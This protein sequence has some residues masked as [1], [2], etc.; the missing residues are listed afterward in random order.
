MNSFITL[1]YIKEIK[2][3]FPNNFNDL[4]EDISNQFKIDQNELITLQFIFNITNGEKMIIEINDE[5]KYQYFKNLYENN[6]E[7]IEVNIR[8]YN[9]KTN[10]EYRNEI[11]EEINQIRSTLYKQEKNINDLKNNVEN[12]QNL[13]KIVNLNKKMEAYNTLLV[14]QEKEK[15]K[16][17]NLFFSSINETIDNNILSCEYIENE[18]LIRTKSTILKNYVIEHNILIKNTSKN[19]NEWP[20]DTFLRCVNDDSDIYFYHINDRIKKTQKEGVEN[21]YIFQ[22]LVLFKNYKNIKE[23]EYDL[24]YQLINDFYGVIGD[25]Y[26]NLI[27]KVIE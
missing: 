5:E 11:N 12:N 6:C 27:I 13:D 17:S 8:N 14:S 15:N 18:K 24:K 25:D 20:I 9:F 10:S 26:G 2:M 19:N 21:I 1:K 16:K 23:G 7:S 4:I 22:I 3:K